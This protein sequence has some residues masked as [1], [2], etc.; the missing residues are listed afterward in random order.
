MEQAGIRP[1]FTTIAGIDE[2]A[3]EAG[4]GTIIDHKEFLQ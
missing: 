4:A 1:I 3:L 2:A